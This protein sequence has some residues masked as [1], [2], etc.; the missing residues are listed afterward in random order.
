MDQIKNFQILKSKKLS[1]RWTEC[2]RRR[3]REDLR[4]GIEA[5]KGISE[6]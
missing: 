4:M 3:L 5:Y 1:G 2:F 6:L